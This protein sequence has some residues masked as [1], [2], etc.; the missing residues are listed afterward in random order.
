MAKELVDICDESLKVTG[1]VDREF[2]HRNGILHKTIHCWFVDSDYV[3][4]Q[5]RGKSGSFPG[6][7]DVTAGGHI[8]SGEKTEEAIRREVREELGIQISLEELKYV[9]NHRFV[10]RDDE[11][12]VREFSDVFLARAEKGFSTF[13]PDPAEVSGIAAIPFVEGREVIR[14]EITFLPVRVLLTNSSKR[15]ETT[16]A[17][18]GSSF[19]PGIGDYFAKILELGEI[20]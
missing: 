13:K 12:F 5:I 4:F 18:N 15:H 11:Q 7:L 16:M 14:R 8:S 19:V 6:L 10:Y 9:G 3:Y 2:A 1:I 17:I 20:Y